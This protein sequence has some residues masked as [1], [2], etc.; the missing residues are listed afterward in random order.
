MT[1]AGAAYSW[2]LFTRP[3]MAFFGWSSLQVA[4]AF[5]IL[6][7]FV[8]VGAIV[9]GF[10]HDQFGPR[11]TALLGACLWGAGSVLAGLG[12]ERFGL[13]WLYITY[14][15]IGGAGCGIM[16]IVPGATVTKWFP[17][18]RGL[19]NGIILCGFGLGSLIFNL[20]AGSFPAFAHV[21]NSA[22]AV[23][24]ARNAAIAAGH[25]FLLPAPIEHADVAVLSGLFFW[26]GAVFLVVGALCALV[27][28]PPPA[29]YRVPK[30]AA[31][32][33]HER[34]FT[35]RS[36][37]HTRAFYLIWLMIF[38]NGACGLALFSNAVPIYSHLTGL[39]GA[40]A[41]V[42]FG[43]I[44][45]ANGVGRFLWAWLSDFIG[46]MPSLF[47]CLGLEGL[48]LLW[49]AHAGGGLTVALAFTVVLLCFGGIFGVAPAVMA[50][51]YGTR[52]LGEDYSLIITAGSAAG[53]VGPLLV[54]VLEDALGSLTAW[55]TPIAI[56]LLVTAIVPLVTRKP[57]S[58]MPPPLA[59]DA[60][61]S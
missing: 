61:T 51:F 54:A 43:W 55:L 40:A 44:S 3:L 27:L 60:T 50:D 32:L 21:A 13:W 33:A 29:G 34:D 5:S 9:G 37:L 52:F 35:P 56:A 4:L 36:M 28:H 24:A 11:R 42:A 25:A 17:E 1:I 49:I 59:S 47:V 6:I 12:L 23:I 53:L 2:S 10:L 20:A 16:Y 8:G 58:A 26:S 22:T 31:K 41:T 57:G 15:A 48:S 45:A 39:N 38:V 30:A 18:E 19:A 14:G 7:V 46:R